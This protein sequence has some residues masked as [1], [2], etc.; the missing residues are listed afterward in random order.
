M[1]L[2]PVLRTNNKT[3]ARL[4]WKRARTDVAV[5]A[6]VADGRQPFARHLI[7]NRTVHDK[8]DVI[9]VELAQAVLQVVSPR[10]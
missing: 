2:S 6:R 4:H 5:P 1:R 10:E 9:Q 7:D 3:I 8:D